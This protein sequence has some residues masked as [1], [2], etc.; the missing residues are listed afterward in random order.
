M[1]RLTACLATAI[2]LAG[3]GDSWSKPRPKR[4]KAAKP[5]ASHLPI[6]AGLSVRKEAN[7]LRVYRVLPRSVAKDLGLRTGDNLLYLNGRPTSS[8]ADAAEALKG[9]PP[10]T[11]LSAVVERSMQVV[12]LATKAPRPNLP[13]PRSAKALTLREAEIRDARL[14]KAKSPKRAPK[15]RG[16][17]F[18][19][20]R[21]E[22]IWVR[23]PKGIPHTVAQ[24]DILEG[25]TSTSMS[26]DSQLDFLAIPQGSRIWAQVLSANT[27]EESLVRLVKLHIYKIGLKG[28][29]TYSCSAVA[30]K[31]SGRQALLRI[32]RGGT[33]IGAIVDDAPL[34]AEPDQN[35]Q[36]RFLNPFAIHEPPSYYR[37]GPG[38]WFKS[39]G[40]GV[41][42][43]FE[44]THVISNRSAH[45]AGIKKGDRI[46]RINGVPANRLSFTKA[47]ASLYG[48]VGTGVKLD[49]A[50]RSGGRTRK[51][52]LLRGTVYR[53]GLGLRAARSGRAVWVTAVHPG[54]PAARFGIKK[55]FQLVQIGKAR[56]EG[57]KDGDL[58]KLLSQD[59]TGD[60]ALIVQA[61]GRPM[62]TLE[63]KRAR[64]PV[65]LKFRPKA[66]PKDPKEASR[67]PRDA[68]RTR[69][70][71]SGTS[72]RKK[73]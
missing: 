15:V 48:N 38:V 66:K 51:V 33:I 17:G 25:V 54:S 41:K 52:D 18:T 35:F 71:R 58:K 9:W 50:P 61:P 31:A 1:R 53:M 13:R 14:R 45:Q 60:K 6:L 2:L 73:P 62:K 39:A 34:L 19:L 11:R 32:S 20:S 49:I 43:W 3:A 69:R 70:D 5:A 37:S 40:K 23:F 42:R 72:R 64:Y 55:G 4:S 65:K 30:S 16:S 28:G 36:I 44:V 68:D 12:R 21:G 67:P 47:I 26:T 59:L 24:G 8:P 29:Q 63:I 7:G 57:V 27:D 56:L 46:T 22:R 10:G